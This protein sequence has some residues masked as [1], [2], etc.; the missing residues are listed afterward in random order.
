MNNSSYKIIAISLKNKRKML[1]ITQ[2]EMANLMSISVATLK[3][4]ESLNRDINY[5]PSLVILNKIKKYLGND[6]KKEVEKILLNTNETNLNKSLEISLVEKLIK[7]AEENIIVK[8]KNLLDEVKV[9]NKFEVKLDDEF[10]KI[11]SL[12][13]DYETINRIIKIM[14]LLNSETNKYFVDLKILLATND[15]KSNLK[16]KKGLLEVSKNLIEIGKKI[17]ECVNENIIIDI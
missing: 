6:G 1:G 11:N 13:N 7:D 3:K 5:K 2:I 12:K 8:I 16:V 15:I 10:K 9:E 17:E 14:W 4:I